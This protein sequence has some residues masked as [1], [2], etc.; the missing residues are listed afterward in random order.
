M[1]VNDFVALRALT[2]AK[3]RQ[4][5]PASWSRTAL[6]AADAPF[7]V[8][9]LTAMMLHHDQEHCGEISLLVAA[10]DGR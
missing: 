5:P 10:D 1:A 7:D 3:L 6:F 8:R 9:E 4:L 2:I